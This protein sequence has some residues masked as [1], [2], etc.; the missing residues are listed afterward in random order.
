MFSL[1]GHQ[2]KWAVLQDVVEISEI[3][4][5]VT[6]C[7]KAYRFDGYKIN[8]VDNTELEVMFLSV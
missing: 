7:W 1:E 6:E 4:I 8:F 5:E 2:S 3:V